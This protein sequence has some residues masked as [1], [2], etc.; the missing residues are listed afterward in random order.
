MNYIE[1]EKQ[2]FDG[3]ASSWDQDEK[4][5]EQKRLSLLS[6]LPLKSTK[7]ILDI[8]CGTGVVSGLLQSLSGAQIL[9]IDLSPKMIE[10]ARKKYEGNKNVSFVQKD[11][12]TF[13]ETGFDFALL[14]NSYPHFMD[15]L[16]LS[17]TL[18]HALLPGAY[19][20]IVHSM[21]RKKLDEHHENVSC[22]ISRKLLSPKEE[23]KNF[24]RF[25]NLVYSI[26]QEDSLIML[27][28]KK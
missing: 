26:D 18:N 3:L 9:G 7:N 19:F 28:Q 16:V 25:F 1:E 15:V 27:F 2:F 10:I 6:S 24:S 21:G 20:A 17:E 14:Y 13:D 4:K 23:A 12:L 22:S 11:F 5:D 8:G